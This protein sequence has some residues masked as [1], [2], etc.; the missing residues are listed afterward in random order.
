MAA[1]G[2][3]AAWPQERFFYRAIRTWTYKETP[4]GA[5]GMTVHLPFDWEP[6]DRRPGIVFFFGG[7]WTGGTI[8][9]FAR[10]ATYLAGR[11]MVA[12][13]AD[14]RVLSR[15]GTTVEQGVE[16]AR[17]AMRWLRANAPALGLDPERL[18]ASGGSAGGYLAAAT[19][20]ISDMDDAG[21]DATISPRPNALLLFNPALL[22]LRP[23]LPLPLDK[24]VPTQELAARLDPLSRLAPDLPPTLMFFGDQDRLYPPA[25]A[26][27]ERALALGCPVEMELA[28]GEVHGF[29]N[30]GPWRKRTLHRADRFLASLGYLHGPPTFEAS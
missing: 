15:H 4:Q 13:R 16:D 14:Y 3:Q 22:S 7:G 1:S 26:F 8:E 24:V 11:G 25:A 17:S 5:L 20:L 27:Y 12:A 23:A 21:D 9:H 10:Q 2:E 19:H 28:E 30:E 6:T 18:V 29:F